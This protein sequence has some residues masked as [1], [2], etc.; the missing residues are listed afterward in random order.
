MVRLLGGIY[1]AFL[2]GHTI[3]LVYLNNNVCEMYIDD[4]YQGLC[5][6]QNVKQKIRKMKRQVNQHRYITYRGNNLFQEA[7]KGTIVHIMV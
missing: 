1:Y 4:I 2:Y 7:E 6:F 3:K 5:S